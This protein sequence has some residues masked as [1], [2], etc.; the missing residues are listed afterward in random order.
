MSRT[1][2]NEFS[3]AVFNHKSTIVLASLLKYY[4]DIANTGVTIPDFMCSCTLEERAQQHYFDLLADK[5][6]FNEMYELCWD[7]YKEILP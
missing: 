6:K 4:N 1:L 2:E 5:N 3:E 7:R